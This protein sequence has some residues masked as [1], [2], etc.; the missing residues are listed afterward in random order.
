[1]TTCVRAFVI[2]MALV[3]LSA[4]GAI[5]NEPPGFVYA[6]QQVNGGN[7]AIH[8][9]KLNPVTGALTAIAGFPIFSG[10]TGTFAAAAEQMAYGNGRLF[11]LNDGSDTLSVYAV[12]QTTGAL[13]QMP[14]SPVALPAGMI[15]WASIAVHPTGSPVVV[16][17]STSGFLLSFNVTPTTITAAAGSPYFMGGANPFSIAFSRGGDYVYAGG[18]LGS[19]IAGFSVTASTGVLTALPGSPYNSGGP[20]P[21]GYAT[22]STGRLFTADLQNLS[23]VRVFTTSGGV[24]TAASGNPFPAAGLNQPVRGLLHPAGYYLVAARNNAR[25]GV[26]QIGGSGAATTLTAVAGSPFNPGG[27]STNTLALAPRDLII[28]GNG[29]SRNLTVFRITPSTG[30]LTSLGVQAANTLGASGLVTGLAWVPGRV[31]GDFENDTRADIAVF[32]PSTGVWYVLQSASNYTTFISPAW[33]VSTDKVVAADYDGDG[34]TDPAVF[35]P[36]TGQWFLLLSS[37]NYST[38]LSPTFGV[39]TDTPVPAD[40][41]GDG[42]ADPA[43]YRPSTGGWFVLRSS[44][45]YTTSFTFVHGM[46]TDTPVAGDFDGDGKGDLTYFR[47]S[48]GAWLVRTSSTGYTGPSLPFTFGT[49]GDLPVAS[50]YDGDGKVDPAVFR[51]S[52]GVWYLLT[53]GSGYTISLAIPWGLSTDIPVPSDYDGDGKS[54]L[55]LF[56]PS[57]ATWFVKLSTLGFTTHTTFSWGQSTDVPV[58]KRP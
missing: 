26:F 31:R 54:D 43:V 32:R 34:K 35:R 13:T 16:G 52:T 28:A 48:T 36:S 39:S 15:T 42:K 49:S 24:P 22:D 45:N 57:T 2:A 9:F 4:R 5:A 12:N 47:P 30:A 55:G 29:F 53:S 17:N 27:F 7:N 19:A 1:M 14:Y 21:V 40:Y 11:V 33:G 25:V 46:S 18:N 44:T 3:V 41:D 56:R 38:F 8:G 10:G 6:F 37:T 58:L 50:D 51:P 20:S 23:N